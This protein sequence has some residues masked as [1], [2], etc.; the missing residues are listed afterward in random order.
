[1]PNTSRKDDKAIGTPASTTSRK[2]IILSFTSPQTF[3]IW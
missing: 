2:A 3:G 1:L